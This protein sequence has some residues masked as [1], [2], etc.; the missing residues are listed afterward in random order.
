MRLSL[1]KNCTNFIILS[2]KI[3]NLYLEK[4]INV[5]DK[6]EYKNRV[7]ILA[8]KSWLFFR[9]LGLIKF[10]HRRLYARDAIH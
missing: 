2:A 3:L 6:F 4:P 10:R 1:F 9:L 5:V 8:A 7:N